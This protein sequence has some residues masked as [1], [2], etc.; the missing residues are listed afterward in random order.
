MPKIDQ[1]ILISTAL[2]YANGPLHIGHMVGYVQSDIWARY[3]RLVGN[4]CISVCASDAHG[5]P[6]MLRAAEEGIEPEELVNL[7][8]ASHISDFEGF[9]VGFDEFYTTHSPENQEL[10]EDIF[11][12]L[13]KAGFIDR[14]VITQAYDAEK[15]MFLPDRYVTGTCPNCKSPDQYGD[16]CDKCSAT[17]DP[18]D[19]IDP[20]S[21]VSGSAPIAKE[22]EHLFF[23][24]SEFTTELDG[25]LTSDN[26]DEAVLNKLLE[27]VEAGLKDWDIS[28]DAPYFGFKI[29]GTEDKYFYVWVDA[30]VGYLASFK[31]YC[32]KNNIDFDAYWKADSEHLVYH[33]IGKDIINFH[34]LFWP[35][36]LSGAG[37]RTPSKVF[38]HGHLTLNKAKMSKSK[39]E[40]IGARTYLNHLDPEALRYYF[41]TKLK[42]G[43][44]DLDFNGDDFVAKVNSDLVNKFVNIASR[45]AGFI[46]RNFDGMLGS[47]LDDPELYKQFS[48]ASS[49]I[50]RFYERREYSSAARVIMD[51]A[52]LANQ[53][54]DHHKPWKLV[55]EEGQEQKV[56]AVCTQGINMFRALLVYLTPVLPALSEQA[57][58]FL[59][60]PITSWNDVATPLLD[61]RVNQFKPLKSR[62][63]SKKVDAMMAE[64]RAAS[65]AASKSDSQKGNKASPAQNESSD[66][67]SI[68]DFKKVDLRVVRIVDAKAVEGADKLVQLTLDLG[69]ST[70]NV[71]AGIKR[72]Y[73]PEKLIG[74]LTVMVA[75][76]APRKMRFGLSE[77]MVLAA[78][79]DSGVYILSPDNGAEPGQRV[80]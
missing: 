20:I 28:R 73:D 78:S 42:P 25:W 12:K 21:K 62:V 69:D 45:C 36:V 79:N 18:L 65:E 38:A 76:L 80:T 67:I 16:N 71:F 10:V 6:I 29:P 5:T 2:P 57:G 27:W 8:R 7:I 30:P 32:D 31:H 43:I 11:S 40:L 55:K 75:N 50:D 4:D 49:A 58:I 24:L 68:D 53:Y 47:E 14:R 22:S 48:D 15:K 19:L 13:D 37:Y 52:D 60:A 56:Q 34:C 70:R 63:E 41:F 64:E 54:V 44:D 59:N 17:Y 33:F 23:K 1:N 26:L 61:H 39:G 9:H 46:Q 77:G 72:S 3:Q 35:A 66:T 51:L 74:R